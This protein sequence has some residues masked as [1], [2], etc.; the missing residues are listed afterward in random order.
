MS[1]AALRARSADAARAD[2]ARAASPIAWLPDRAEGTDQGICEQGIW[3]CGGER[4]PDR[5]WATLSAAS[6]AASF[7]ASSASSTACADA[8]CARCAGAPS[9]SC[10]DGLGGEGVEPGA[11]FGQGGVLDG[12]RP[13]PELALLLPEAGE[14]PGLAD[15]DLTGVVRGWRR[16]G[17]WVAA[18]E[19]AAVAE[20]VSRRAGEAAAAGARVGEAERYAAAEVAAALTLTRF[21]AEVLVGRALLL[22]ELPATWAA[23]A[24]GVI[25]MP[26]ALVILA[27]VAVLGA[28][29]SQRVEALVLPK[30]QAQTTGELRKAVA[31]AVFAVDPV[32]ADRRCA[33]AEKSA[34]V[35]RWAEPAGTGAIAGRDLPPA[36]VLAAD[37]RVN[38][39]AA[40]LR[41]D[42]VS[43]GMDLL[44]AQVFLGLLLG[45]PVAA[46]GRSPDPGQDPDRGQDRGGAD[47]RAA[48]Q[49]PGGGEEPGSGRDVEFGQGPGCAAGPVPWPAAPA[50]Q[51]AAGGRGVTAG[52]P[53]VPAGCA[54]VARGAA[55]GLAGLGGPGGPASGGSVHLTVPL[56]ALLGLS[57]QPGEVAGFGPVTPATAAEILAAARDSH[58]VRWCV[59]VTDEQGRP[60]GHGCATGKQARS[61]G[62][63]ALTVRVRA[64]AVGDCAH[65]RQSPGYKPPPSLRHLI[66]IR[67]KT[68]VF[69]GCGRPAR[70]C[71]LDHTLAY[72]HGGR[73]CDCNLAPLCRAHHKVKQAAGWRLEQPR[74][75][76][77]R[78]V[79]PSGWIYT[80]TP[81]TYPG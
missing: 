52:P 10:A 43:G 81:G 53:R 44:R 59:T 55:A 67:N 18:M 12:L 45:R 71:D 47:E 16:L 24:S 28:E 35:E 57:G 41:A 36:E 39:L 31:R 30:A 72:D 6:S 69:P 2:A 25:D 1:T 65:G 19:H 76:V 64:L 29:L 74:P 42:G 68:C 75:G 5:L 23:L 20:L 54:Q 40:A 37:N 27:G 50:D 9:A 38:A 60:A 32:A 8:P 73:T 13:G 48:A 15:G 49:S 56:P 33:E 14:L 17:S 34:R 78:W 26:K 58:G 62:G 66:Q 79:T 3:L 7:A 77:L 21:S 51:A 80:T 70:Q 11:G 4:L 63:W 22:A 46:A 61:G